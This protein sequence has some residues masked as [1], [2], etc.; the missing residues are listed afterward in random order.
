MFE[1][2]IKKYFDNKRIE[3]VICSSQILYRF[4]RRQNEQVAIKCKKISMDTGVGVDT[5]RK[6]LAQFKKAGIV[7]K[8]AG[9]VYDYKLT[10]KGKDT[11][12]KDFMEGQNVGKK[13]KKGE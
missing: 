2:N 1:T 7:E 12:M 10:Q 9:E 11:I 4:A 6:I 8:V 13:S 3:N 5:V